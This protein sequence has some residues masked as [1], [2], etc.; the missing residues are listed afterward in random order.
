MIHN[1]QVNTDLINKGVRFLQDTKGNP[2]VNFEELS[3]DDIV[4]IPAFGTTLSIEAKLN[5]I[6]IKPKDIIQLVRSLKRYGTEASKLRK[7][8]TAL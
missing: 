8:D 7:K 5:A 2:L 1:P 6:G 4:I 3:A